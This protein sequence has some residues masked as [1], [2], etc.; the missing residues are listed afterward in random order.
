[1]L[2]VGIIGTGFWAV[3]TH[4]P[5][6]AAHPDAEL[7]G[8]WGRRSEA[9]AAAAEELHTRAFDD[10]HEMLAVVDA[11]V[12]T[13]PPTAQVDLALTC[14]AAGKHLLLEKPLALDPDDARRIVDAVRRADLAALVFFTSRHRPEQA[15]WIAS[16]AQRQWSTARATWTASLFEPDFEPDPDNWRHTAGALWDVGPHALSVALGVLGEAVEVSAGPGPGDM[17]HLIVRH[18]SGASSTATL[19]L[20]TPPAASESLFAAYGESGILTMPVPL[21]TP[22]EAAACAIGDLAEMVR[23]GERDH[24]A[25]IDLGYQ[26]TRTLSAAGEALSRGSRVLLD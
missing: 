4:G 17:V 26:V 23:S 18:R 25:G 13:V 14:A 15:A 2:R 5:V 3:H 10:L 19:S 20:T 6:L 21:S 16:A 7:V 11:V 1:M 24:P 9:V 8:V 22:Q 12:L